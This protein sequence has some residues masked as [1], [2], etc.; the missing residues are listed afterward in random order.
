MSSG[1][2]YCCS[3]VI[4]LP[5]THLESMECAIPVKHCYNF[6]RRWT[7]AVFSYNWKTVDKKLLELGTN[8]AMFFGTSDH[9]FPNPGFEEHGGGQW[10]RKVEIFPVREASGSRVHLSVVCVP[11]DRVLT[12]E[13]K[14]WL[15]VTHG[16]R[17]WG[18]QRWSSEYPISQP[19]FAHEITE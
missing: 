16:R 17:H 10:S 1:L 18:R 11:S 19:R 15:N 14:M 4:N 5:S 13:L 12:N 8:E 2:R 3:L 9:F 7:R 6:M